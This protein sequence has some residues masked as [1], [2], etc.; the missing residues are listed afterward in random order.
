MKTRIYGSDVTVD[1]IIDEDERKA[2]ETVIE[3]LKSIRNPDLSGYELDEDVRMR[4]QEPS[5][6]EVVDA[7]NNYIGDIFNYEN[8]ELELDTTIARLETLKE[9]SIVRF[10]ENDW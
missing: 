1:L 9:G 6:F 8:Y 4:L 2:V 10:T 5:R 7:N 3:L